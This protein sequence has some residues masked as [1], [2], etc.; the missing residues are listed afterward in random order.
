MSTAQATVDDG[1]AQPLRVGGRYDV[2]E[3]LGR[4]G[5]AVVYRATDVVDG[6]QVALKQLTPPR[7][8][9]DSEVAAALFEREFHT[10]AELSHPRIIEVYD[11]GLAPEGAYYTMELLDGG[12]LRERAPIPWRE[13]C[14]LAYEICSSL[15]LIHSRRLVHRDVSPRN[16]RCT[17][18]GRAKLIDFGAMVPIGQR[19][20]VV[21]TPA[22]VSPEVVHG[23]APDARADLFSFGATLYYALTGRP[24]YPAASFAQLAEVWATKPVPLSSLVTDVPGPL[25]ALVSSLLSLEPSLRP[26]TA[27]DVMRRLS[28][29]ADLE[30]V[31]PEGVTRAYLTAPAVVGRERVFRTLRA[32]MTRAFRGR[33]RSLLLVGAPGT[34]RSRMLDAF[35]LEAKTR[36]ATVLRAGP[37]TSGTDRFAVAQAIAEELVRTLPEAAV[38]AASLEGVHEALFEAEPSQVGRIELLRSRLLDIKDASKN[39]RG[40]QDTLSRWLLRVG[41]DHPLVLAVDDI[42]RI[43]GPS[44]AL[45]AA[46]AS[47]ASGSRLL[48]VAT[49]D[50]AASRDPESV[51][52][53]LERRSTAVTLAP[54]TPTETEELLK[55]VFGDTPGLAAVSDGIQRI[56]AGNPRACMD[57][58]QHLVDTG[59]VRYDAGTWTL[60]E[61]LDATDIPGSAEAAI[62]ARIDSL[63]SLARFIAEA[64]ALAVG[65]SFVR[66]SYSLLCP[67]E[68]PGR[69]DQAV[70]ELLAQ[71]I[72]TSDGRVYG[73]S[74]EGWA[75]ALCG[76]LSE[77]EKVER[78]RALAG[79]LESTP[80]LELVHHLLEAGALAEAL[81]RLEKVLT[82]AVDGFG[83]RERTQLS[84]VLMATILET[85]LRASVSLGRHPRETS[86]LRRW[87]TSLSPASDNEFHTRCSPPWLARLERDSGLE[88]WRRLSDVADPS[89]RRA[90]ALAAAY[91]AYGKTPE[92][93]RVYS[94][95][96]AIKGLVQYVVFSIAVGSRLH[97]A[98]LIKSL[99]ALLEPFVPLSPA[100]EAIWNN[101]LA[102][103]D[104]TCNGRP[105]AARA[106]WL[107]VHARLEGF[108]EG[109]L[110]YVGAIRRAIESGIGSAEA[111]MGLATATEWAERLEKDALHDVNALYLRKA[112]RLELG[113]WEGAERFRRQAELVALRAHTRQMFLNASILELTAHAMARDLTGLKQVMDRIEPL[114]ARSPSWRAFHH[115]GEGYFR[116][117]CD[118]HERALAAFE[119]ALALTT[120]EPGVPRVLTAFPLAAAGRAEALIELGRVAEAQEG[121][122]RALAVCAESKITVL[123]H[124]IVRALALAE[125]KTGN[126]AA[127]SERLERLIREQ[128][129]LGVTGLHLGATYE[130]R[131]RVA[132]WAGDSPSV[133]QF[134]RLT[135]REYRHGQGSPLA[136][137]YQRLIDE[138]RA[139]VTRHL[140]SL[141]EL[142]TTRVEQARDGSLTSIVSSALEGAQPVR[143]RAERALRLLC[144]EKA[145]FEAH[146]YLY[147][148][149]GLSL[150]ASREA[151]FAP[152]GLRQHLSDYLFRELHACD[153][154]T[155]VSTDLTNPLSGAPAAFLDE[156]GRRY[157]PICLVATIA[158]RARYA[159]VAVLVDPEHHDHQMAMNLAS[160]LG[161]HLMDIGDAVGI[162]ADDDCPP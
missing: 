98:A 112:I 35:G 96:E 40:L 55:S 106:R 72:L 20:L 38:T 6:R 8:P 80:G 160:A 138:S 110:P 104:Y 66:Q 11:Y 135:A 45:I 4:G 86:E 16:V 42:D 68:P 129:A 33:G 154:E 158:G 28:A 15:A 105:E 58:A 17:T 117:V 27:F 24:A 137:R 139:A 122:E 13:A 63:S 97:D 161:A 49:A 3:V 75:S 21:G 162:A 48:V 113:D 131:A 19:G 90:R 123:S 44:G 114:A 145:R 47:H 56:S 5:M 43:D 150:V 95:D 153:G 152:E 81:D 102:T 79:V 118:E 121:A 59:K 10:L 147:G 74:H 126:Y 12:D 76:S 7:R 14:A 39:S 99:P 130:A 22:F 87:V 73:L 141:W 92:S 85:A 151:A 37:K 100:V 1:A 31:E 142:E 108:T 157:A 26:H 120:P 128:T 146:L 107:E 140:P 109:Q 46:L 78:H 30:R 60:P 125:A 88:H 134:G 84:T 116:F 61:R 91:E 82:L 57:L 93:E 83:L 155:I 148:E 32:H 71:Q 89:E 9:K 64:Q 51:L 132:I 159:G 25:E 156:R 18:D 127:A 124:V 133:Q 41:R 36:G 34:G 67:K 70:T 29:I 143:E 52:G 94:P 69:V 111:H 2:H 136:A 101:A 62:R 23:A 103:D 77:A 144:G 149:S 119:Q 54:L 53:V 115:L 50:A 65:G